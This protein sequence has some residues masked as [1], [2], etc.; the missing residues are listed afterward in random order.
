MKNPRSV[1]TPPLKWVGGKSRV[2]PHIL[3]HLDDASA[4]RLIEPF[5]GGG[6]VFLNA[7]QSRVLL[8]DANSDLVAFYV[9]VKERPSEY[10]AHAR[11]LFHESTRTPERYLALRQEFNTSIDRFSRAVLLLYLNKFGFNGL[12]RTNSSGSF[13]VPYGHRDTLPR[14]PEAELWDLAERLENAI[15]L[16]GSFRGAMH[17]A[18]AGDVVYCDP[19]YVNLADTPSFVGYVAGGFTRLDQEDLVSEAEAAASRGATVFVSNHNTEEARALYE[20]FE[21][22]SFDVQRNISA[23]AKTRG[24]VGEL[25]AILR[26]A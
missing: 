12:Y 14:F 3:P 19:P 16:G 22:V 7:P 5:V 1:R 17:H 21:I 15:V 11:G 24:K 6:S 25:L 4:G 18:T 10:I 26:P 8:N 9:A 2:L 23:K 20:G 13:N